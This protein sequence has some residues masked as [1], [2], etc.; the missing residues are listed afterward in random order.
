MKHPTIAGIATTPAKADHSR[1][2]SL[3]LTS[4]LIASLI[5]VC[6]ATADAAF[7]TTAF[8]P[9][10]EGGA[11]NGQILSFGSGGEIFELDA[12]LNV[13]GLDLNGGTAGTSAQL[14]LHPLPAGLGFAFNADL[15]PDQ[16]GLLL[17]YTFTNSSQDTFA[18]VRFFS[19]V[20]AEIDVP[21][22]NYFN[23]AGTV[24]GKIGS[25]PSDSDPDTWEID[26]PGYVFGDV[27]SNLLLGSLDNSNAVAPDS[28]EDVSL[29]LGFYLGDLRPGSSSVIR[30]LLSDV[31]DT[32][33]G[34]ALQHFDIDPDSFD[35]LT[36]SGSASV[37]PEVR[38][39]G[40]LTTLITIL[41]LWH[42]RRLIST[43]A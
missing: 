14:S 43:S 28:P 11:I 3:R 6:H 10:W 37:I 23:E 30:I 21:I 42:A 4:C 39:F 36:L 33:G 38:S 31:G 24:F 25:G 35:T 2:S 7:L 32:L 40:F 20:D 9:N 15:S 41:F 17:T 12:F 22:N 26:E 1:A 29:V 19:F 18:S 16:S 5:V 27:F 34:F 8:G 13:D